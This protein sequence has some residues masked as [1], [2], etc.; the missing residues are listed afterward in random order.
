MEQIKTDEYLETS[1]PHVYAAGDQVEYNS[2]MFGRV[3]FGSCG[4]SEAMGRC[5]AENMLGSKDEF[6]FVNE[7]G[8][9][10]FDFTLSIVGYVEDVEQENVESNGQVYKRK[11]KSGGSLTGVIS[12]GNNNQEEVKK[13]I[14][15]NATSDSDSA[16]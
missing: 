13:K 11:M 10:H 1:N 6:K 15:R 16:V 8:V 7:Y 14:L 4:H 5:A 2:T 12:F 3:S 9:G